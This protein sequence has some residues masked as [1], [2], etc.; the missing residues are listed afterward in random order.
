[1]ISVFTSSD[2]SFSGLTGENMQWNEVGEVSKTP[3]V[4]AI[5][6]GVY[7]EK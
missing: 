7:V 1:M 2:F 5:E 4:F 6:N 3:K